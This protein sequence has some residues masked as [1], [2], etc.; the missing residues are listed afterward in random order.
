MVLEGQGLAWLP[1]SLVADEIRD[2]RLTVEGPAV[3][4]DIRLYRSARHTRGAVEAVWSA[5]RSIAA[6]MQGAHTPF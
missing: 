6:S 1:H 5:A 3:P 4:L 2:G